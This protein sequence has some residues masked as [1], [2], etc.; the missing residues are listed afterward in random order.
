MDTF[1]IQLTLVVVAILANGFFAASEIGLVSSRIG[2]LAQLRAQRVSGASAAIK[3]KES[4][5]TFLATIQIAITLVAALAS[6]VGGAAAAEELAPWL[7][8]LRVPGAP[9]WAE[10]VAL[11]IVIVVITYVSLIFGELTPKAVALRNPERLACFAAPVIAWISRA[12]SG[13]VSFLTLSTN[14]VLRLLGQGAAKESLFV[15]EE[16]VK[17]LL[18]E[19]AAKGVFEKVEEELVHNVFEFADT[20]VREIMVPRVN[21]LGVD[22]DTPPGEVLRRVAEI[23]KSRVPV[24]RGSLE[25]L[26]GIVTIKDL[27]R[28][29]AFG[30]PINLAELA[31]PALF[32]PESARI[33]ALLREFQRA[34]QNVALV[35]DE[36]G[37]LAGM[38]TIEDVLEEIVG[39]IRE[40]DESTPSYVSRLPD[41]SYLVDGAAPVDEVREALRAD[42]PESPDY[43]TLAGFML[44]ALQTVPTR[45][46]SVTAGGYRWTVVEMSGPRIR[47][48]RA[49]RW[50]L[51]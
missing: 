28:T 3:L 34:R 51:S 4:P 32:V 20:T 22:V 13:L 47:K 27:V 48:V 1:W 39:E 19:G 18:R 42:L 15:S 33:S 23:G 49:E 44:H 45:G 6:A 21:V 46:A 24:Y 41:G 11:G 12:A 25:H 8:S 30:R 26:S 43:S 37:G 40:E 14:A 50:P 17:Y 7:A 31:R 16:D 2:R 5:E 10:P 35:V 29:V 36:Y 9:V 38:V